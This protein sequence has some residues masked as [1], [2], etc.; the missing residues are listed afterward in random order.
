MPPQKDRHKE[1]LT[2]DE[3]LWIK[4]HVESSSV[5]KERRKKIMDAVVIYAVMGT[6]T[7]VVAI[8]SGAGK[9]LLQRLI[10][11]LP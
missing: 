1:L 7:A 9:W 4:E 6:L 2:D 11:I 8:L 10:D 5:W 3:V